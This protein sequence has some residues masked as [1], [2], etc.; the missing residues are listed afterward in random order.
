MDKLLGGQIGLDDL[1]YAHIK[2]QSKELEL[3]KSEASLGLTITDNGAG[4]S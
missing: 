4:N 2:G 1:I 3:V